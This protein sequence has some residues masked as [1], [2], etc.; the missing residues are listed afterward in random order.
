MTD[1]VYRVAGLGNERRY[2][3]CMH[4]GCV[5]QIAFLV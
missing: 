2:I 5:G 3:T 1:S 4:H